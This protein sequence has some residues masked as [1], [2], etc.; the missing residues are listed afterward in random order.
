M[1]FWAKMTYSV[2]LMTQEFCIL[3]S[4]FGID[5]PMIGCSTPLNAYTRLAIFVKAEELFTKNI[6]YAPLDS[7]VMKNIVYDHILY[8]CT[9]RESIFP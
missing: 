8:F 7:F 3:L 5:I 9:K 1:Q 2:F 6:V 4:R